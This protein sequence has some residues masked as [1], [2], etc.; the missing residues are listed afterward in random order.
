LADWATNKCRTTFHEK[1]KKKEAA[2]E[3]L[4]FFKELNDTVWIVTKNK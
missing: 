3:I 2:I 4:I 1:Y